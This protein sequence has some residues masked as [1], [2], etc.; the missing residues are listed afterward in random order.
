MYTFDLMHLVSLLPRR[1][2][3]VLP[4]SSCSVCLCVF[5][6]LSVTFVHSV[7]RNKHIFKFNLP[8]GRQ[9][10]YPTVKNFEDIF[11]RFDRIFERD[12]R[13]DRHRMTAKAPHLI[14]ASRGKKT[15]LE[16]LYY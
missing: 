2:M 8:M 5:V 1:A 6:C 9:C 13:T 12:R 11:I 7:K 4:M 3:Q 10:G 14:L 16:V 15:A